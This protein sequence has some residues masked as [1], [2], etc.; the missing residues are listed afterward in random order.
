[1]DLKSVPTA[2][3]LAVVLAVPVSTPATAA[4]AAAPSAVTATASGVPLAVSAAKKPKASVT[5]TFTTLPTG[6]VQVQVTSNAAKVQLKYRTAKNKKRTVNK[7]L[8]RG[9]ATITLPV[10]SKTITVRAKAPS[11]LGAR[12]WTRATP[13]APAVTPPVVT[14]PVVTPPV[15]TPPV[16]TPP[17]VTPPVVPPPPAPDTTAPGPVTGLVVT[18]TTSTSVTLSWTNPTDSDLAAVVVNR[19]GGGV[20]YEGLAGTFTDTGLTP[21]QKYLYMVYAR[22]TT[23]NK[24]A[25]SSWQVIEAQPDGRSINRFVWTTRW[26]EPGAG[27]SSAFDP[28][29]VMSDSGG[30]LAV[31]EGASSTRVSWLDGMEWSQA[32]DLPSM[33]RGQIFDAGMSPDGSRA[34]L[35]AGYSDGKSPDLRTWQGGVWSSGVPVYVPPGG[36]HVEYPHS[37][38]SQDAVK[39]VT[40]WAEVSNTPGVG[41]DRVLA[42][43]WDGTTWTTPTPLAANVPHFSL[44]RVAVA[45]DGASAMAVWTA[46]EGI[47]ASRWN[48]TAWSSPI[49]VAAGVT[50]AK[51]SVALAA[52]GSSA[53]A[54]IQGLGL[55]AAWYDGSN[56]SS[57]HELS[58]NGR[59][60]AV[61]ISDD[62]ARS[63]ALWSDA[64]TGDIRASTHSST[65]WDS[66]TAVASITSSSGAQIPDRLLLSSDG[67]R[68]ASIWR[69]G[70]DIRTA[71][72]EAGA[73][74]TAKTIG[75]AS[76]QGYSITPSLSLSGAL[77]DSDE[78]STLVAAW[79]E[80]DS[81]AKTYAP[82]L[83]VG[84]IPQGGA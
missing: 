57:P 42:S 17:V 13:P 35:V 74:S 32:V 39:A 19:N 71:V 84:S 29:I 53:V 26:P 55:S 20:V 50:N 56:W 49:T 34:V 78:H 76:S 59:Q 63:L 33:A 4:P 58:S 61:A 60:A 40:V 73:W 15:V 22:D 43:T 31:W 3:V 36:Y 38:F 52:D 83:G 28:E 10:G 24:P 11:K 82:A 41:T 69:D 23:G 1:M 5:A 25:A 44:P 77:R 80:E 72:L 51:A 70:T 79:I 7:K 81:I 37:A 64:G 6:K 66:P 27:N 8:K 62:G 54:L 67:T 12:P 18:A 46:N 65:G 14:P 16:V 21:G 2:V 47:Q 68:A 75:S 45:R 30:G 9:A 48:G